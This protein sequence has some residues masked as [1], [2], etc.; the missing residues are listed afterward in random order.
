M[1]TSRLSLPRFLPPTLQVHY[2]CQNRTLHKPKR[3]FRRPTGSQAQDQSQTISQPSLYEELF[4]GEGQK[5]D[6]KASKSDSAER[7]VPRLQLSSLELLVGPQEGT[8]APAQEAI[9]TASKHALRK[10]NVAILV[11]R[12]A[13]KS[14]IESDFRRITPKGKHIED[15][16]GP[17]D[18][19]KGASIRPYPQQGFWR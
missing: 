8:E 2:T 14:L 18:I 19:L 10:K 1:L 17:G 13:S 9:E 7:Q 16:R 15:W 5:T 12:A 4:P 6:F 11:L 3:T